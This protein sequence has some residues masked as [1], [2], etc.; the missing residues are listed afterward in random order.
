[1]ATALLRGALEHTIGCEQGDEGVIVE[2]I[3]RPGEVMAQAG[4]ITLAAEL[5]FEVQHCVNE[6]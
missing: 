1:M 4:A 3:D 5:V 2:L 6:D